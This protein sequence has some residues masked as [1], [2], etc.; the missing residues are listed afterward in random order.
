VSY[1]V[2]CLVAPSWRC[3]RRDPV[4]EV[5]SRRARVQ[6]GGRTWVSLQGTKRNPRFPTIQRILKTTPP[7]MNRDL[8]AQQAGSEE[9]S[10]SARGRIGRASSLTSKSAAEAEGRREK[11][12]GVRSGMGRDECP[13]V[14]LDI[15]TAR[16]VMA[17]L[18][19][20][21]YTN[22]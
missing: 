2:K 16:L 10:E 12:L 1:K 18:V 5:P 9:A 15:K 4:E 22:E 19:I 20:T 17:R 7:P 21:R 14:G 11:G 8:R 3:R 13:G 6:P